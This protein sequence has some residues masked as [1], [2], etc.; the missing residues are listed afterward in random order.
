MATIHRLK[1]RPKIGRP[2]PRNFTKAEQVI[3]Y[4][5]DRIFA[6]G[7]SYKKL[8]EDTELSGSTIGKLANRSTKW[9]RHTTLFPLIAR[10][11]LELELKPQQVERFAAEARAASRSSR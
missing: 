5:A 4:L 6:S 8:G 11:G 3:E 7:E 2:V 1:A 10:L 9:P